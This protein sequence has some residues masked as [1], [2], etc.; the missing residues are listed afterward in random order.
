MLISNHFFFSELRVFEFKV[1]S[2]IIDLA[3]FG[4]KKFDSFKKIV[5]FA[6]DKC[7]RHLFDVFYYNSCIVC[8]KICLDFAAKSDSHLYNDCS[9]VCPNEAADPN[10]VYCIDLFEYGLEDF[11]VG[12]LNIVSCFLIKNLHIVK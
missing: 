7:S 2:C 3:F 6:K 10:S 8:C 4:I 12:C 5:E 1:C 9:R 11:C